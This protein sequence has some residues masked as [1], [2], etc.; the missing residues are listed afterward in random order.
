[1]VVTEKTWL[2]TYEELTVEEV[3]L[4]APA[5]RAGSYH[6][7]KYCENINNEFILCK[8]ELQDPRKCVNYGKEVT[9]CSLEFFRKVKK[10]CYNEFERYAFCLDKSDHS[11]RYQF[12]RK[13]QRAFNKCMVENLGIN[14]PEYDYFSIPKIHDSARPKPPPTPIM[15]FDD[16]PDSPKDAPEPHSAKYHEREFFVQ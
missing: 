10:L 7:G 1:M 6:L 2:P 15:V 9:K 5:L 13:T 12:C 8:Q 11:L 4:G 14:R 3:P 16:V